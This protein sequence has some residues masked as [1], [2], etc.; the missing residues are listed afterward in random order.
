MTRMLRHV[1]VSV[2]TLSQGKDEDGWPSE[3]YAHDRYQRLQSLGPL[4]G[5][6]VQRL[7][8]EG[9]YAD[10]Q[11]TARARPSIPD[12]A[13]LVTF[14]ENG[15]PDLFLDVEKVLRRGRRVTIMLRE[16]REVQS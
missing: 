16:V 6:A 1:R 11:A 4:S 10:W 14:D 13:R 12:T 5:E 8:R 3:S 9:Y 15:D 7:Q 2:R